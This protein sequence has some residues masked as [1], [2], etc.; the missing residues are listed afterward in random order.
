MRLSPHCFHFHSLRKTRH[1]QLSLVTQQNT[2]AKRGGPSPSTEVVSERVAQIPIYASATVTSANT[3]HDSKLDRSIKLWDST[4]QD[5]A[6]KFAT[7]APSKANNAE[8]AKDEKVLCFHLELLYEAKVLD[9]KPKDPND[10]GDGYVYKIHYKGWKNT[11]VFY[12]LVLFLTSVDGLFGHGPGAR[13]Q[14]RSSRAPG[15][16]KGSRQHLHICHARGS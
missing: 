11:Y 6:T 16:P 13:W 12:L 8:Y 2:F 5:Y 10:K 9:V 15:T 1:H 3:Y 4:D 7:M 14:L